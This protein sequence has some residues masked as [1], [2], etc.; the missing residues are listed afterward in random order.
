M[1][2]AHKARV[3]PALW[4]MVDGGTRVSRLMRPLTPF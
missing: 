3:D 4:W 2:L 1:K